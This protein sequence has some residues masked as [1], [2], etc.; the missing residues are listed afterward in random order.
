MLIFVIVHKIVAVTVVCNTLSKTNKNKTEKNYA[1]FPKTKNHFNPL[2]VD[3]TGYFYTQKQ[4]SC[5]EIWRGGAV[6]K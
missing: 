3:F 1:N 5:R 4:C 2:E 6:T